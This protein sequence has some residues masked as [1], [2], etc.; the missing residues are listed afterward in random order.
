[1]CRRIN[2]SFLL[3]AF[4]LLSSLLATTQPIKFDEN[5]PAKEIFPYQSCFQPHLQHQWPRFLLQKLYKLKKTKK[6]IVSIVHIGDSHISPI[7]C[8]DGEK[9]FPAFFWRRG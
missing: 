1:M 3:L 2:S 8:R 7:I 9:G 6:G 5:E 4:F